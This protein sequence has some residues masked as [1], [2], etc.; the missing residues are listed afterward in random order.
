[1]I[2]IDLGCVVLEVS[3]LDEQRP[4]LFNWMAHLRSKNHELVVPPFNTS[5]RVYKSGVDTKSFM[6]GL[7]RAVCCY[8]NKLVMGFPE[9][10]TGFYGN[11]C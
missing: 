1:M 8:R 9:G 4:R 7:G 3:T 5:T 2:L 10:G 6:L 11:P